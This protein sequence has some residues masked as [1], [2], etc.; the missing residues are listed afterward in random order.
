MERLLNHKS[1]TLLCTAA[2]YVA[3]R[4]VSFV[5]AADIF[6]ASTT[7]N[8]SRVLVLYNQLVQSVSS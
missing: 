1:T 7:T 4:V 5:A 6:T 3:A 2:A 8:I